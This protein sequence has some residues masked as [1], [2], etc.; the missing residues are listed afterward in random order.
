LFSYHVKSKRK[1][2]IVT[3]GAGFEISIYDLAYKIK[4]IIGFAGKI[5][6][7]FSKPDGQPRRCLDVTRA[8]NEFNFTVETDFNEGLKKTIEW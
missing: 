2:I 3:G 1:K 5:V 8:K 7:D 4:N 6:F